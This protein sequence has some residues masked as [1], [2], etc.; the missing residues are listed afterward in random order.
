MGTCGKLERMKVVEAI[1]RRWLVED[2]ITIVCGRW[3]RGSIVEL[4]PHGKAVLSEA[5][6]AGE[7]AG[8]RDLD[9]P[10]TEHHAHLDLAKLSRVV[11]R[12]APSVC[13][14][15]RSSFEIC[16]TDDAAI[17]GALTLALSK[18]W[19]DDQLDSELVA[20]W[21]SRFAEDLREDTDVVSLDIQ[22]DR[23]SRWTRL[24]PT[25][26]TAALRGAQL[27]VSAPDHVDEARLT[28]MLCSPRLSS[29]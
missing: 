24:W 23:T 14:G 19:R 9:I 11:Y 29:P 18:P 27:S 4:V 12:V 1:L 21:F 16:F 3:D 2:E 10:G 6:Y 20:R 8:L 17:H 28:Q 15:F 22:V 5:K 7:F 25:I 13:F 26:V